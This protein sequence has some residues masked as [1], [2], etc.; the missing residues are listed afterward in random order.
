MRWTDCRIVAFDTET[1]GLSPFDG[2]RIIEFGAVEIDVGPD[3]RV[4]GVKPHQFFVDP[5]MP[6]P[7]KVA[8]LT[9]ITEE[10]LRGAPVF[11]KVA[12]RVRDLLADAILVAHNIYFDVNFI[13]LELRR[14]GFAWPA[15]RAEVDTLTLSQRLLPDLRSHKL[16][17]VAT[18]LGISLDNAHRA[19]DDAEATGRVL[20]EL[21]R[22]MRAPEDLEE[23]V[24]W[25]DA[26]SPPPDT[27]H[28]AIGASGLPEFLD[29]PHKGRR[30]DEAPDHLQWMTMA[31]EL[32]DGEWRHR[33]PESLREWARRWLRVRCSGRIQPGARS[34]GPLD[35]TLEPP[36]WRREA[37]R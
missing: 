29:G 36:P 25:A 24:L 26:A 27:G 4:R 3:G 19:T 16:E 28:L 1:T 31:L 34:Q 37:R 7:S 14:A 2:D 9:G 23:F 30:A 6:I 11:A 5:E 8:R 12:A 35:W 15:V 22:R 32:R 33:Y 10:H 17:A 20:V 18:Q 13:T 21:A